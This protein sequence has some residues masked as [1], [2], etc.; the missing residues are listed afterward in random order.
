MNRG[1]PRLLACVC[2]FTVTAVLFG[3]QQA[4]DAKLDPNVFDRFLGAYQFPSGHL[5]VVGRTERRL[6]V[7]E[8][9][10]GHLRGLE[11]IDDRTWVADPSLL[12]FAPE[13]YRLTFVA[14][15]VRFSSSGEPSVLAK[16]ANFYREQVVTFNNG[17]ATF[18][19]PC[20]PMP[21]T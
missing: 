8:P 1:L 14:D 19:F 9:Q 13:V 16:R 3:Q 18:P 7:Y 15:G 20:S 12:V 4:S 21:I 11:R 2:L 10:S 17:A 5:L 6:Y